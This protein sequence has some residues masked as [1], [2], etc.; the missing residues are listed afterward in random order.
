MPEERD[1]QLFIVHYLEKEITEKE[2]VELEAWLESSPDNKSLFFDL[3]NIYESKGVF[4]RDS[5][6]VREVKEVREVKK[7]KK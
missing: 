3:K 4:I 5:V 7:L 1:I 6:K 2:L